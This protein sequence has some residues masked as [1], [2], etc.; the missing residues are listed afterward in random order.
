MR[1]LTLILVLLLACTPPAAQGQ[2]SAGANALWQGLIEGNK[3]FV[4]GEITYVHLKEQRDRVEG[5]Q[6]PG[7]TI[8][9]CSDSRVPPELV[10]DQSLGRLVVIRI[11]G[12]VVDD[13]GLASVEYAVVN[14]YTSLIVVLGHEN[15][16]AVRASLLQDDPDTPSLRALVTRIRA[17]FLGFRWDPRDAET[18]RKAVEANTRASAAYLPARSGAIRAAIHVGKVKVIPAYY[19]LETGEVTKIE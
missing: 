1:R 5:Q 13:F 3:R 9:S 7:I 4:A 8:L 12:S 15:C 10:F 16:D 17:S 2:Q 6:N 14:G 19:S 18:V 11:A